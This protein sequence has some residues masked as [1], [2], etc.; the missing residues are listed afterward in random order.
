MEQKI[1]SADKTRSSF[2]SLWEQG[3]ARTNTGSARII[4]KADGSKPTATYI[5]RKGSL[6]CAEHAMIPVHKGYWIIDASQHRGEFRI[7]VMQIIGIQNKNISSVI[8]EEI[9]VFAEGKWNIPLPQN[10]TD[11]V[12]AAQKKANEYHCRTVYFAV[13][14]EKN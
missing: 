8:T 10:L 9:Y 11:A 6:A 2:I 14:K 4:A 3:G 7:S 13:Q 12:N 5:K 1:I